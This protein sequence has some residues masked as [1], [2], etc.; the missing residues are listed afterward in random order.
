M[1]MIPIPEDVKAINFYD[2]YIKGNNFI[3]TDK[4]WMLTTSPRDWRKGI[5]LGMEPIGK[6]KMFYMN[7]KG[8]W[9]NVDNLK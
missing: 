4:D 1:R 3:P 9:E 2:G 5:N 8:E 6:S 7:E